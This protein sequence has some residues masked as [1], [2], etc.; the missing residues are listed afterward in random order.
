MKLSDFGF[1]MM[2]VSEWLC[3]STKP[4]LTAKPSAS[5]TLSASTPLSGPI[6]AILPSLTATLALNQ[7]F[8]A[9]VKTLPFL[10]RRSYNMTH[11]S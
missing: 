2:L 9:P 8:P 4:G 10:T 3:M 7:G 11:R 5:I 6:P 1:T